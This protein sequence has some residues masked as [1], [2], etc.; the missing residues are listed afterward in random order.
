MPRAPRNFSMA[1]SSPTPRRKRAARSVCRR[2]CCARR[3]RCVPRSR[4]RWRRARSSI[5]TQES[6]PPSP[7]S[8]GL[9]PDEDGNPVGRVCIAVA[10]R[11]FPTRDLERNYPDVGRE[12]IRERAVADALRAMTEVLASVPGCGM[13]ADGEAQ[14]AW[15]A[16][17]ISLAS[18]AQ[19]A[20]VFAPGGRSVAGA[21]LAVEL[22]RDVAGFAQRCG[23][24]PDPGARIRYIGL[25]DELHVTLLQ[26]K[27]AGESRVPCRSGAGNAEGNYGSAGARVW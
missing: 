23:K 9:K 24:R 18:T 3:A 19:Q 20:L 4:A 25:G 12:A 14:A 10:Q 7:A 13:K 16:R 5:R 2:R 21:I 1:A 8:P 26:P 27:L 15:R 11:G 22:H 17:R 6:P